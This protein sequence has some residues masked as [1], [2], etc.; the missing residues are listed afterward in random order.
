LS[1]LEKAEVER[2]RKA[3]MCCEVVILKQRAENLHFFLQQ[4]MTMYQDNTWLTCREGTFDKAKQ[5]GLQ[6]SS[7]LANGNW[8]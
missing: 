4:H 8:N 1:T 2:E 5:V 7:S 3:E 6:F